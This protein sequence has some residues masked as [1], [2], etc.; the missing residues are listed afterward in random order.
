MALFELA[1]L[2]LITMTQSETTFASRGTMT[3]PAS[4][5]APVPAARKRV[6]VA[7]SGGVDSSVAAAIMRAAGHDVI[8]VTLQLYDHGSATGRKGS[9]CAG[10][11]IHDARRVAEALDIPH[12]VLDY[13]TRFAAKVIETFAESYVAG[14]TPIPCVT[15]NNEIK[16]RDLLDTAK[17]LGADVLVTGHY[18]QRLDT[19]NGPVLARAVDT[20]RDQS[21]FL[22]G[23]T[24]EQ[25]ASLW[26]PIGGMKKAD[27][28]DLA[29]E[30]NLPVADKSDSQDICFV[31]TGKYTDVIERLKPSALDSG[32]IVHLDG[33]I[34]G[35]HDGIV[36][37]TVGQRR[38]I[39]IP[40]AE[41]LYVVRL[42]AAR[43]E[44]IVGPR[45]AL[46]TTGL[47]LR[48]V[49]WLGEKPLEEVG[50]AGLSLYVRMRSS[51]KLR[52]ALLQIDQN[53]AVRI[54]LHDGEEGIATGQACVFY[55]DDGT[56]GRVLG[57]GWIAKTIKANAAEQHVATPMAQVGR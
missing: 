48:N 31:P 10:Q 24:K 27:V 18:V 22:F 54:E 47:V 56:E 52:P 8:G 2:C 25:L 20:D 46:T 57:G 35:R 6:V 1:R 43:N 15:C 50:A 28:R 16:F 33:R 55:A 40:A 29:R 53:G 26:F 41:P 13:E 5:P 45:S 11:D 34:L 30:F 3:N 19:D 38:G 23:I 39:K 14:E 49:N 4:M 44:V 9:C 42:D 32:N 51:Q 37:Y 12:Y 36:H 7:M 17:D 21:Y